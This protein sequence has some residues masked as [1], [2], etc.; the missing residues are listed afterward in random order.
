[1][2]DVTA[3]AF[4]LSDLTDLYAEAQAA[5]L[6]PFPTGS[7][8]WVYERA[9]G[10]YTVLRSFETGHLPNAILTVLTQKEN[11]AITT[12]RLVFQQPITLTTRDIGNSLVLDGL[13]LSNPELA[14]LVTIT[15]VNTA[16][17]SVDI[18]VISQQGHD[19]SADPS[20][21]PWVRVLREV[22]FANRAAVT[23]SQYAFIVADLVWIDADANPPSVSVSDA[24][25]TYS[26]PIPVSLSVIF[27]VNVDQH[28]AVLQWTGTT[29]ETV[30]NQPHRVDTSTISETAIYHAGT[31]SG[32]SA[33]DH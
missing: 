25:L 11:A 29:W 14:G 20:K 27:P 15:A 6:P 10:T 31:Q 13:S 33:N 22:R 4:H 19:F 16:A 9:D 26:T 21:A 32:R 7:S 12:T 24:E 23:A 3:T 18:D 28:W 5:S 30:R 2:S 8:T 17:K 1:M